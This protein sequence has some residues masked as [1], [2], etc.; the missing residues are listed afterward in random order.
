M[1]KTPILFLIFN[2]PDTTEKVFEKIREQKPKYLYVAADGPRES[3]EGEVE[4]CSQTRSIINKIDWDCE[5]K[6]LFREENFGCKKAISS[7]ID[8]FFENVEEGIILEDD[9]VPAVSFF[10]FC[11][12]MLEKYRDDDRIFS[13]SGNNFQ[14]GRIRGKASYYF[15][16]L[17]NI[18]GWA[19]WKRAWKNY[20]VNIATYPEFA[21]E[22]VEKILFQNQNEQEFWKKHFEDTYNKEIDSWDFQ[23]SYASITQHRL[24]I[25]PNKNMVSNIGFRNDASRTKSPNN[26]FANMP[27]YELDEIV[28]PRFII[29]DKEA[30]NYI[31]KNLYCYQELK[32]LN[33][34]LRKICPIIKW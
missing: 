31:F 30:D 34:I 8:W 20:D 15:S 1:L 19:T 9:C 32:L 29:P 14:D 23:L 2:R 11:E 5:I 27:R 7:A 18:W 22:E 16:T 33:K 24:N 17:P 3:K 25:I 21:A 10:S 28:H 4:L 6:T 13:V 12:M 26:K